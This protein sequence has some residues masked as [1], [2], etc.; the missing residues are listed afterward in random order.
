MH[1]LPVLVADVAV[2]QPAVE[3]AAVGM[4]GYGLAT[5]EVAGL[6]GQQHG[7]AGREAL[8]H[9]LLLLADEPEELVV[10][11]DEGLA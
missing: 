3:R 8:Q 10:D 11:G 1:G 4:A 2:F 9:P 7:S 6:P 5:V